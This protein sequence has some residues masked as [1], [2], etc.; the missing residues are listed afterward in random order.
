MAIVCQCGKLEITRYYCRH[1]GAQRPTECASFAIIPRTR[2]HSYRTAA[3]RSLLKTADG[4]MLSKR[5]QKAPD[6]ITTSIRYRDGWNIVLREIVN[7][8]CCLLSSTLMHFRRRSVYKST[9]RQKASLTM[10]DC[11]H[12]SA[13]KA[14]ETNDFA[15]D[16]PAGGGSNG[17][18]RV[19]RANVYG[20]CCCWS[21]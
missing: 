20:I 17:K 3:K 21:P 18:R 6:T 5:L 11:S 1:G 19:A 10:C 16:V 13:W 9:A 14:L 8:T 7:P 2:A 12:G 15:Y 4:M